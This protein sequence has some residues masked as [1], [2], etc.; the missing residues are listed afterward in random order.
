MKKII[1]PLLLCLVFLVNCDDN[2]TS[3][4]LIGTWIGQ[5]ISITDC[6]DPTSNRT[7]DLDCSNTNC[8]RLELV[9]EGRTYTYQQGVLVEN[10]T[11]DNP[12][13]FL[14]CQDQE[15]ET[16]CDEFTL[17]ENTSVTLVLST[18]NEATMC[19]TSISFRRE[20]SLNPDDGA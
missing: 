1:A 6:T 5:S 12:G 9:G 7:T 10:G 20:E 13:L 14:L 15:G 16:I 11:W 4:A 8:Y 3:A 19:K 17:E 18:T 2:D